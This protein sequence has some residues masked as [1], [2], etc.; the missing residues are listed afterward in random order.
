MGGNPIKSTF[1]ALQM[2]YF[3]KNIWWLQV[4]FLTLQRNRNIS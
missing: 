3:M 4:F 1:F 2:Q